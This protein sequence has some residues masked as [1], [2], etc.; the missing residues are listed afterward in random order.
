MICFYCNED[1]KNHNECALMTLRE[2]LGVSTIEFHI[3]CFEKVAGED[4]ATVLRGRRIFTKFKTPSEV[5]H[6]LSYELKGQRSYFDFTSG[7]FGICHKCGLYKQP[8][9][10]G[11][12]CEGEQSP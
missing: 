1:I 9:M 2:D 12:K 6:S 7:V 3:D 4:Y 5:S 8:A 11:C 10:A